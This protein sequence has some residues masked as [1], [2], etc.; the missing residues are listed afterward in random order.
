[1][2]KQVLF[3]IAEGYLPSPFLCYPSPS[4]PIFLH[5]S[6]EK[7]PLRVKIFYQLNLFPS[8]PALNLLFSFYSMLN[9]PMPFPVNQVETIIFSCKNFPLS[10][11]F[12]MLIQ[13]SLKVVCHSGIQNRFSWICKD[14]DKIIMS[15]HNKKPSPVQ[16][17]C[18]LG[19]FAGLCSTW[20]KIPLQPLKFSYIGS[21]L[22]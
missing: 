20:Y 7:F 5:F 13:T 17:V 21:T 8:A 4:Y 16:T 6:V 3:A 11:L 22:T 10:P 18:K 19:I 12:K 2:T 14:V 15:S 1:M 9:K